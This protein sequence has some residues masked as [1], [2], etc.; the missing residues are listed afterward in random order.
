MRLLLTMPASALPQEAQAPLMPPVAA[1]LAATNATGRT[2]EALRRSSLLLGRFRNV[3]ASFRG[4]DALQ[5]M[6]G[7]A[8]APPLS[9]PRAP[10]TSASK[11]ALSKAVA[12]TTGR[13]QLVAQEPE[14][15]VMPAD[16]AAA[17]MPNLAEEARLIAHWREDARSFAQHM[18]EQLHLCK[19]LRVTAD[20]WARHQQAEPH[21]HVS[22]RQVCA[23]LHQPDPR[24]GLRPPRG[25]LAWRDRQS[26]ARCWLGKQTRACCWRPFAT[27]SRIRHR[28]AVLARMKRASTGPSAP[29][30]WRCACVTLR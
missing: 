30:P 6:L 24:N 23:G 17:V 9:S 5:G 26:T 1:S 19:A 10:V 21:R 15:L 4:R 18:A 8:A 7:H 14:S 11:P 13:A 27:W 3:S 16:T 29:K 28:S 20:A 25:S 12:A 2:E 22:G